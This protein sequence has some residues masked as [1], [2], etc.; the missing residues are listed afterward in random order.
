MSPTPLV[1][2]RP[3]RHTA[4]KHRA[5]PKSG[6]RLR[7]ADRVARPEPGPAFITVGLAEEFCRVLLG[8]EIGFSA[9]ASLRVLF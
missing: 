6:W 2:V 1:K 5:R 9:R 8:R 3:L 7:P 4:V